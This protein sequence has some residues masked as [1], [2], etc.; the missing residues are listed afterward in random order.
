MCESSRA[1]PIQ[2][3]PCL[4][5]VQSQGLEVEDKGEAGL[6]KKVLLSQL[7][8]CGVGWSGDLYLL[9]PHR[10]VWQILSIVSQE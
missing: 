2:E 10:E 7:L 3:I 5:E 9:G 6:G 4:S 8:L 1:D